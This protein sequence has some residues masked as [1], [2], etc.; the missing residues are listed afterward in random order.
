MVV[1]A[2][3]ISSNRS[4]Q[5][6]LS[7]ILVD[8]KQLGFQCVEITLHRSIVVRASRLAHTLSYPEFLAEF[9]EFLRCELAASVA[10]QNHANLASAITD[11]LGQ[12]V[13]SKFG[14]DSIPV[15]T[16]DYSAVIQIYNRAIVSSLFFAERQI[17]K[18]DTPLTIA[19]VRMEVLLQKVIE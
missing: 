10:V 8:T 18:V 12:G 13:Y 5:L 6:F 11:S 1:P 9:S 7:F 2:V 19:P 14:I 4:V 15:N 17:S 16:G 3:R